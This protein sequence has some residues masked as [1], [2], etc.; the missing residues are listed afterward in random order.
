MLFFRA[1]NLQS[2][3]AR[4]AL[5]HRTAGLDLDARASAQPTCICLQRPNDLF[6]F[7]DGS[8]SWSVQ[9]GVSGWPRAALDSS[10]RLRPC[11]RQRVQGAVSHCAS[12]ASV[13]KWFAAVYPLWSSTVL[14]TTVVFLVFHLLRAHLPKRGRFRL[15][16]RLTHPISSYQSRNYVATHR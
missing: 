5:C 12:F 1:G 14:C 3:F 15:V 9:V 11:L 10:C 6:Q 16:S 8:G 13:L 4:P 2:S 7:V